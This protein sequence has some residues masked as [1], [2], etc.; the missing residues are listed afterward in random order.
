MDKAPKRGRPPTGKAQSAAQRQSAYRQRLVAGF[1]DADASTRTQCLAAI[2]RFSHICER[3]P[4]NT[5][6]SDLLCMALAALALHHG[7]GAALTER[8]RVALA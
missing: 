4:N 7:L 6:S 8:L 1:L 3:E 2:E 5:V